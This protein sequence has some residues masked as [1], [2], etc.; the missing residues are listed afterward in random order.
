M[1]PELDVYSFG[2]IVWELW[3]EHVPFDDDLVEAQKYV[4]NEDSRPKIICKPEDIDIEIKE[5]EPITQKIKQKS[6]PKFEK[7]PMN[8]FGKRN[9]SKK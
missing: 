8:F 5:D 6:T 9:S 4:I 2:L 1:T 7:A 3:H